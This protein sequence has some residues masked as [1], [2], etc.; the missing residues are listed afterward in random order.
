MRKQYFVYILASR[1][2]GTLYTGMTSKLSERVAQHQMGLGSVFTAR[3]G[4]HQLVYYE[5][6][7]SPHEAI[8]REKNVKSW[9]RAWKLR[10]IEESNP[11]WNDLSAELL[12]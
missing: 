11:D 1:R 3:Y 2:N 10:L 7:D 12:V 8:R 4:V 5:S 9:Q 6:Y